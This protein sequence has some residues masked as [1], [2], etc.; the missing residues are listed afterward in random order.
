MRRSSG[1]TGRLDNSKRRAHHQPALLRAGSCFP[2]ISTGKVKVACRRVA[3]SEIRRRVPETLIQ[4]KPYR[5][6]A[7]VMLEL[8][9]AVRPAPEDGR[10][11]PMSVLR[12]RPIWRF[13]DLKSSRKD[14]RHASRLVLR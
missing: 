11:A 9:V 6:N 4:T 13:T 5:L 3:S 8:C 2:T 14:F 1:A 10:I 12:V 7:I